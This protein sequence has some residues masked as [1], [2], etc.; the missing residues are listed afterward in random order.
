MTKEY[1]LENNQFNKLDENTDNIE[2][3]LS[4][5]IDVAI[6]DQTTKTI[7]V[8]LSKNVS[9]PYLLASDTIIDTYTI[10]LTDATGLTAGDKVKMEQDH[11]NPCFYSGYIKSI[12]G[13]VLTLN[14]PMDCV[15]SNDN[16]A[17][18]YEV[19]NNMASIDGSTTRQIYSFTN[20][21]EVP[22]DINKLLF[23]MITETQPDMGKFGDITTIVNGVVI[24]HKYIDGTY[25]TI[26]VFRNNGE[27]FLLTDENEFF[28]AS[29][30]GVYG[31]GAV[32]KYNGLENNGV[33]IRIEQ[34]ESLEVL[35]QDDITDITD[36]KIMAKGSY[37]DEF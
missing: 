22:L 11:D 31:I 26:G 25:H 2:T 30:R 7:D 37:T 27:L 36:F 28:D 14:V 32:A 29:R 9:G 24:R 1:E 34:N 23:K 18:L 15:F 35:I 10:T 16:D 19:E 20:P 21:C 3:L 33:V 8:R 12:N 5:T 6:Q 13:N 4:G 17:K